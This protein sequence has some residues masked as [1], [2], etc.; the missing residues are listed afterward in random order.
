MKILVSVS[1]S[2]YLHKVKRSK[3]EADSQIL[4]LSNFKNEILIYYR[5]EFRYILAHL[6]LRNTAYVDEL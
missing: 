4:K 2:I 5:F 6:L 1:C 3:I